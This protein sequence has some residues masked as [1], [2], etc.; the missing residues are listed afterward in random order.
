MLYDMLTCKDSWIYVKYFN[1]KKE[2]KLLK[3]IRESN[4]E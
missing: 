3:K 4:N 1:L 2:E